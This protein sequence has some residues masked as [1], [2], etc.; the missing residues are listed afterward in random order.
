MAP[1]SLSY[2]SIPPAVAV[3][4]IVSSLP[5]LP[6][7][8][9]GLRVVVL[10]NGARCGKLSAW[11]ASSLVQVS[12]LMLDFLGLSRHGSVIVYCRQK[13]SEILLYHRF[14]TT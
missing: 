10:A 5:D 12:L 7:L 1:V 4:A 11:S 14:M 9:S 6:P 8:T 3:N 13:A 2:V